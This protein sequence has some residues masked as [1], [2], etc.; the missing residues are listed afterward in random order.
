MKA[1][2]VSKIQTVKFTC[3]YHHAKF[4]KKKLPHKVSE[5]KLTL[6]FFIKSSKKIF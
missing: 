5:R 3:V 2:R 6:A 1:K 4:G